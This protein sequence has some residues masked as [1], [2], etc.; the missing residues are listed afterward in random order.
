MSPKEL[1]RCDS[2]TFWKWWGIPSQ[3]REARRRQDEIDYQEANR[4]YSKPSVRSKKR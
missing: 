1:I 3:A 2:R 4:P